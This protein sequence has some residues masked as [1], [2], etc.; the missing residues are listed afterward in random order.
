[1][2]SMIGVHYE[3]TC[4]CTGFAAHLALPMLREHSSAAMGEA[5]AKKLMQDALRVRSAWGSACHRFCQFYL[6][7]V[8][9]RSARA[10]L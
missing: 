10:C 7:I 6:E 1:M 2:V 4:V 9:P 8:T 5:D 3:D